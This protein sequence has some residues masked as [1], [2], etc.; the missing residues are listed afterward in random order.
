MTSTAIGATF[1]SEVA[2]D[3][4]RSWKNRFSW[5]K[6]GFGIELSG[7]RQ[8]QKFLTVVDAR[9]AVVHGAGS[10]TGQQTRDIRKM[11][12]IRKQ[13]GDILEVEFI[14]NQLKA[15]GHTRDIAIAICCEFVVHL[16][17]V[18]VARFPDL[19]LGSEDLS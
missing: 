15:G 14:G 1:Y 8:T 12:Q 16:D 9:N 6:R 7:D 5:L 11:I 10:L 13:I 2:G 4:D 3:I 18:A 19:R 17:M